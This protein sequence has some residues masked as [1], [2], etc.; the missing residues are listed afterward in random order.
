M[1]ELTD[2]DRAFRRV[3]D[4]DNPDAVVVMNAIIR[5]A[6]VFSSTYTLSRTSIQDYVFS[7]GRRSLALDVMKKSDWTKAP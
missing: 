1:S 6:R 5:E 2:E 4:P 3:F 7:E